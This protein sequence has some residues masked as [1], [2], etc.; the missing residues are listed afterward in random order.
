MARPVVGVFSN[1]QSAEQA[2]LDLKQAGFD[3]NQ[4]GLLMRNRG[5]A[6]DVASDTGVR[7]AGG[8]IT[9]G[10]LGGALGTI[11]AATGAFVIPG[12]G[13]FVSAGVLA[14]AIAGGAVGAIAGGLVGLGIPREEADYYES[15]VRAG[16]TLVTVDSQ[17]NE[18]EARQ[19]L[20]RNGAEDTWR[21]SPWATSHG[22]TD[23]AHP[24]P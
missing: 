13:P 22:A 5:E 24:L 19:I 21:E 20:L 9:G 18:M 16:D 6:K 8:A 12:I 7:A 11:L 10:V 1:S 4:I 23:T 15:R 2:I 17:G 3:T 14:T